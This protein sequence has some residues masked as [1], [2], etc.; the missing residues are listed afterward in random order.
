MSYYNGSVWPLDNAIIVRGLKKLGYAAEANRIAAGLFE[1]ALAH[2]YYRLPEFFCGFTRQ[3]TGK[4]VS[5]PMAC[6]P[7]ARAA[8]SM[9]MMLQAM[10]GL[11]ANAE[12]NM[13]YVHNPV[14]PRWLGEVDVSN[15]RVG[16]LD[17]QP[18]LQAR[19]QPNVVLGARQARRRAH[20]S[21]RVSGPQRRLGPLLAATG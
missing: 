12:E 21:G 4:P 8:A 18:A 3:A 1:A 11:Y 19:G 9:F 2:E 15:L 7:D 10:L 6:S 20:R 16:K 13:L 17:A 14:L 5:Y